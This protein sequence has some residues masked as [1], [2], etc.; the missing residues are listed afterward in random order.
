VLASLGLSIVAS[1]VFQNWVD[2]T[3]GPFGIYGIPT[4]SM[5]QGVERTGI[6][7]GHGD[8]HIAGAAAQ[9][10]IGIIIV[11]HHAAGAARGRACRQHAR[12]KCH[13]RA[14]GHLRG[15]ERRCWNWRTS[16][17]LQSAF[18]RSE[19]VSA[20]SD[21]LSLGSAVRG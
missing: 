19:P 6:P 9:A 14:R 12:K 11:R 2:V 18:Y 7:A 5:L 4:L 1:S 3:N 21:N 17:R 15:G 20:R 16:Y 10:P 8:G 13:R